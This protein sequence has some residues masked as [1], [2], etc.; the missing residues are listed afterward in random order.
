MP[1]NCP[2]TARTRGL[3]NRFLVAVFWPTIFSHPILYIVMR[4]NSFTEKLLRRI[5]WAKKYRI[6][7]PKMCPQN[8]PQLSAC[9]DCR[10]RICISLH[11]SVRTIL[12]I[13]FFKWTNNKHNNQVG[14]KIKLFFIFL[15]QIYVYFLQQ[16]S[17]SFVFSIFLC[18]FEYTII[19]RKKNNINNLRNQNPPAKLSLS[20]S[21]GKYDPGQKP[22]TKWRRIRIALLVNQCE[23]NKHS[24]VPVPLTQKQQHLSVYSE[25]SG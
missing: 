18:F 13:F 5:L 9:V 3:E 20:L 4:K 23:P 14:L 24:Q 10:D 12:G 25:I 15:S 1:T 11:N 7:P 21:P 16:L 8:E 17:L 19:T 6:C 22:E 2:L